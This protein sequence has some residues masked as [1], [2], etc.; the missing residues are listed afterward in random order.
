MIND[1]AKNELKL[2]LKKFD[3]FNSKSIWKAHVLKI[4]VHYDASGND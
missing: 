1:L 3:R 2:W 4:L